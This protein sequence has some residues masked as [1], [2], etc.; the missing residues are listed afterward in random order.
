MY[1]KKP[2]ALHGYHKPPK[3]LST[4]AKRFKGGTEEDAD[5]TLRSI[6]E[7]LVTDKVSMYHGPV[8][9]GCTEVVLMMFLGEEGPRLTKL[10]LNA[11]LMSETKQQ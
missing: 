2:G 4:P 3:D 10:A 11:A 5:R 8:T 1:N 9:V 6:V 7:E